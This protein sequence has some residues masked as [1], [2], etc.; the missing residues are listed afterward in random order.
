M[1]PEVEKKEEDEKKDKTYIK[2]RKRWSDFPLPEHIIE[3]LEDQNKYRPT[4]VQEETLKIALD[5]DRKKFNLLIRAVNGSG[6]TLSFLLPMIYA[7][8]PK[9]VIAEDKK[10]RGK[11]ME[12]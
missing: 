1:D 5:E 10:A 11:V 4:K 2:S 9:Q 6:K 8:E 7:L 3:A 12:N